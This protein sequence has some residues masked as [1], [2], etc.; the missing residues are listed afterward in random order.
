MCH[1]AFARSVCVDV[2]FARK[3]AVPGGSVLQM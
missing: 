2:R 1:A 3:C